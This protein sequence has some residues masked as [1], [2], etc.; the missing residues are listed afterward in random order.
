MKIFLECSKLGFRNFALKKIDFLGILVENKRK[1]SL[2]LLNSAYLKKKQPRINIS[3]LQ[4]YLFLIDVLTYLIVDIV[5]VETRAIDDAEQ[6]FEACINYRNQPIISGYF[7]IWEKY[8]AL[9]GCWANSKQSAIHKI[10]VD[11]E[12]GWYVEV[13]KFI[14]FLLEN[15]HD[16]QSLCTEMVNFASRIRWVTYVYQI[17]NIRKSRF[18]RYGSLYF[19]I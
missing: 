8:H 15:R 17:K 10:Y 4:S 3:F 16:K 11:L 5:N 9:I 13:H 18:W 6:D 7:W 19:S 1:I 14:K 2:I 12:H